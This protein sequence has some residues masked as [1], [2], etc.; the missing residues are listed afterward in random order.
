MAYLHMHPVMKDKLSDFQDPDHYIRIS[1]Q[2]LFF[3][4]QLL[5]S[6]RYKISFFP[7]SSPEK[8]V[9]GG[10]GRG[11]F[12]YSGMVINHRTPQHNNP[13]TQNIKLH[14]WI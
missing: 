7:N 5:Y 12:S 6:H 10:R 9:P 11:Y 4:G 3:L 8:W 13:L 2:D 1:Y 14:T